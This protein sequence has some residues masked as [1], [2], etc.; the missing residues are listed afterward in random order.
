VQVKRTQMMRRVMREIAIANQDIR[1]F[2]CSECLWDTEIKPPNP[3]SE[4]EQEFDLHFCEN[5]R[6]RSSLT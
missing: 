6:R 1:R 5:Y 4:A 3:K 2:I